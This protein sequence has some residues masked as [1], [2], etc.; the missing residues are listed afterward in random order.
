MRCKTLPVPATVAIAVFGLIGSL[1]GAVTPLAA[2]QETVLTTFNFNSPGGD[3]PFGGLAGDSAG[4]L[5]GTTTM[6]GKGTCFSK[7]G[8]GCGTVYELSPK[9]GG[10]WNKK[11]LHVFQNDARDGTHPQAGLTLDSAGNLY[12]T[13]VYGGGMCSATGGCGTVFELVHTASGW[14]ERILHTFGNGNDGPY[15]GGGVVFDA[16]GN[17]YGVTAGI[18]GSCSHSPSTN[19]GAVYELMPRPSGPW[20]EKVLHYFR[21]NQVDG[22]SPAGNLTFDTQGKLYGGTLSGGA[23]FDGIAFQLTYTASEG[24]VEKILYTFYGGKGVNDA[25]PAGLI[26]DAAGNLY[27]VSSAGG[28][29]GWGTVFQLQPSASGPWTLNVLHN[30]DANALDGGTPNSGLIRDSADNLYGTTRYGGSGQTTCIAW[31]GGND[32]AS[33]GIVYE[34][35]SS[36]SNTWTESVLHDFGNSSDGLQPA[37]GLTRDET[38]NLYGTTYYG[39]VGTQASGTVFEVAP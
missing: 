18:A 5:Y 13:T 34:L 19:C 36:G 31:G 28:D 30:F 17:L 2:Q 32:F 26:L 7:F 1:I 35:V 27:G 20:K 23:Y 15:P 6:G 38:G 11:I 33:C 39:G 10:G 14:V 8:T 16:A 9:A 25:G 24:W 29:F 22:Y 21:Y 3:L 12:G 4:N 37:A